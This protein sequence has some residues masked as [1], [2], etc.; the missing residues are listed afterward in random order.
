MTFFDKNSRSGAKQIPWQNSFQ[1]L[2]EITVSM[3]ET[4]GKL[5]VYK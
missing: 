5:S 4:V 2:Q 3:G 1:G